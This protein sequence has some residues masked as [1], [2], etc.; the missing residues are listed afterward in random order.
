MQTVPPTQS[1]TVEHS[2]MA[3]SYITCINKHYRMVNLAPYHIY[4]VLYMVIQHDAIDN[5]LAQTP[6]HA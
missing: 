3:T 1:A 2:S 4:L 5:L 6:M